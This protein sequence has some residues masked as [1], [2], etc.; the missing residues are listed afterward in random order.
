MPHVVA[1]APT[2][3]PLGDYV[4]PPH[5]PRRESM[6]RK[7]M[8][9]LIGVLTLPY[10]CFGFTFV[11]FFADHPDRLRFILF[12]LTSLLSLCIPIFVWRKRNIIS[13]S[14]LAILLGLSV[15][16]Y[17]IVVFILDIISRSVR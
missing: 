11:L 12:A 16:L 6:A 3:Q 2:N 7:M 14:I 8:F 1:D 13:N 9:L 17:F 15:G 10:V 4:V 5:V